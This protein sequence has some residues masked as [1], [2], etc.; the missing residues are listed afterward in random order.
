MSQWQMFCS[1]PN[2]MAEKQ[3]AYIKGRTVQPK[4][5]RTD[6]VKS[7]ASKSAIQYRSDT[8]SDKLLFSTGDR[9]D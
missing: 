5:D 6:P 8:N 9:T 2:I 4:L 3:L 1:L 7:V